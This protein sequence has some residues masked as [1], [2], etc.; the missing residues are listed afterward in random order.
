M[1][2]SGTIAIS[3]SGVFFFNT[4]FYENTASHLILEKAYRYALKYGEGLV[5]EGFAAQGGIELFGQNNR[6]EE[7]KITAVVQFL[8]GSANPSDPL[9][10]DGIRFFGVGHRIRGNT[11]QAISY[12][13]AENASASIAC[14]RTWTDTSHS[15]GSNSLLDKNL[16]LELETKGPDQV[17]AGFVLDGNASSNTLRNNIIRAYR[18]LDARNS[19]N[20]TVI[21]NTFT[22]DLAHPNDAAP[23]IIRLEASPNALIDNNIFYD[24]LGAVID[25]VDSVSEQGLVSDYNI[26]YR[27]DGIMPSGSPGLH[28]RWQMDPEFVNPAQNDFHLLLFSQAIDSGKSI[29]SVTDDFDGNKRPQGQGYDIGSIEAPVRYLVFLPG[30]FNNQ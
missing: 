17:A 30:L 22:N 21:N 10:A 16:C 23:A 4:L 15:A 6:V 25:A 3:Q 26:V 7:N 11:I 14:F 1:D 13:D 5:D 9:F 8:T 19:P 29:N 27:S 20:L 2:T 18:V 24:P 12:Q 28:D